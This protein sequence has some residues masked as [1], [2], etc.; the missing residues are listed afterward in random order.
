MK[1]SATLELP[2]AIVVAVADAAAQNAEF[3]QRLLGFIEGVGRDGEE[4]RLVVG[5]AH[6]EIK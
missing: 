6:L 2:A 3:R 5:Q 1:R 4:W